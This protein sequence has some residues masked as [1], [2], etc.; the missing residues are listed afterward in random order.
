MQ[1]LNTIDEIKAAV[2][3]GKSVKCDNE[4]YDVIKDNLG[5]YLIHSELFNYSAGLAGVK[6]SIFENQLNGTTFYIN[7]DTR[8]TT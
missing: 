1:V 7:N 3:A 4:S 2:D 8:L 5:R 6:G